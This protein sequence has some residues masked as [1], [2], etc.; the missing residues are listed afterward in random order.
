MNER[1]D[2]VH[3]MVGVPRAVVERER[4]LQ[5][6]DLD[7]DSAMVRAPIFFLRA[8]VCQWVLQV[9]LWVARVLDTQTFKA[10]GL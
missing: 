2:E 7:A 6:V 1:P 3:Q 4:P 5:C 8:D 10:V 9:Q